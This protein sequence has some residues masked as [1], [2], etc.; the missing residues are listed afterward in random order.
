MK[1]KYGVIG[2]GIA[3]SEQN[4]IT[5]GC[6]TFLDS[7]MFSCRQNIYVNSIRMKMSVVP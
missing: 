5:Y 3:K 1:L 2:Y 4:L 7:F 6:F